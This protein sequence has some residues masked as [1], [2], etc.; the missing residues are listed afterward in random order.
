MSK[1][2]A[3]ETSILALIFNGTAIADLAENDSTSP[4]TA[5]Y[6]SL[7]TADPGEA[8]AQNT[9]EATYT[10]YARVAVNRNS[11]GWTV[12]SGAV[13][14]AAQIAFPQCTGGSNAITHWAIGTASS[15]AGAMLYK[16]SF[17]AS[18]AVSN[19]ITPT[20]AA[21]DLDITED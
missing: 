1:S 9:S 3:L 10:S 21:G 17:S 6:V 19:G 4:A 5:L 2:N 16:G 12:A 15:G 11:G 13:T 14:N 20:I 7:H 18:L 8:G